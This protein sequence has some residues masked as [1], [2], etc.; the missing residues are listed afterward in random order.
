[1][2]QTYCSICPLQLYHI[3]K[4]LLG[5]WLTEKLLKLSVFG[6]FAGGINEVES[7]VVVKK[8]ALH[9]ISSIWFYSDEKDLGWVYVS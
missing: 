9:G 2:A 8:L 6:Q 3:S 5:N 4:R 1:M 7:E